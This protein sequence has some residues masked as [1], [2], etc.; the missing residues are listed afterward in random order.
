M[1]WTVLVDA[2]PMVGKNAQQIRAMVLRQVKAYKALLNTFCSG[3]RVE[4]ALMVHLQARVD[5]PHSAS[6][7]SDPVS[8]CL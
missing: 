5:P 4:A 6:P 1:I 8:C 3:A 2:L 7:L